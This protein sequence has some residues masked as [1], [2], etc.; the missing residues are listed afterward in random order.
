MAYHIKNY[1]FL[2]I[3]S[4]IPC[5]S[6]LSFYDSIGN[7]NEKRVDEFL[8][9]RKKVYFMLFYYAKTN[10]K[11]FFTETNQIYLSIYI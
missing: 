10:L 6:Y 4:C 1:F 2:G 5:G 11:Q 7:V 9:D 3:Y 8:G